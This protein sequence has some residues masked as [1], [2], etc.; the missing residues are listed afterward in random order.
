MISFLQSYL[1]VF[2]IGCGRLAAAVNKQEKHITNIALFIWVV[3]VIMTAFHHE[4]WRDEVK[5]LAMALEP[6]SVFGLF[7]TLRN[8]GHPVLWYVILRVAYKIWPTPVVL[9]M[10]SILIAFLA[11]VLF[12][13]RSPFPLAIR[14]LFIFGVLPLVE[15]SVLARNYGISMLLFFLFAIAYVNPKKNCYLIGALIALLANT[16]YLAMM[17]GGILVAVWA[18]EE[19]LH[20]PGFRPFLK[21]FTLPAALAVFG[22]MVAL[23][24][25]LMDKNSTEA[26]P[27]FIF[28]QNFLQPLVKS[29]LHPGLFFTEL[30]PYSLPVRDVVLYC[31]L[32]GLLV[33][34]L[35]AGFLYI[36]IFSYNL[37]SST[38]V[39][40]NLRHQGVLFMFIL[41]LYWIGLI[42]QSKE[43][44]KYLSMMII[45]YLVLAPLFVHQISFA[46]KKIIEDVHAEMSS[47]AALG[48]FI[49][50][51]W[52][53]RDAVIIG[54]PDYLLSTLVYYVKNR[55][56]YVRDNKYGTYER[57]VK[58]SKE[59]VTLQDMWETAERIRDKEHFPVL[60][61]L[62]HFDI[63]KHFNRSN[64][65][66]V[67][68]G[69]YGKNFKTNLEEVL[70]FSRRTIKIA[71]FNHA[72]CDEN[73]ELFLVPGS[74]E[75]YFHGYGDYSQRIYKNTNIQK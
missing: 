10:A 29:A 64:D 71:E 59:F 27:E 18:V 70:E 44:K 54:D 20:A 35:Y 9:Q 58:G 33:R 16:N 3:V 11:V 43:S 46:R 75:R 50:T 26:P 34:P 53:L 22:I 1:S 38:I 47:G 8:E 62:K 67:V 24:T 65:D 32:A 69:K 57:Y 45:V 30:M 37:F 41:M 17:F 31:L 66:Y 56:Y 28:S 68:M 63:P 7:K 36:A 74:V 25:I 55:I 2:R 73:Y 60:I 21:R 23:F 52:Q 14:L 6:H 42:K 61:L 39:G 19:F 49:N 4:M 5:A 15:Y 51:N 40:P 12:V 48:K 13:K 72:F